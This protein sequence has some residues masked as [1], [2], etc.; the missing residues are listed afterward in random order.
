MLAFDLKTILP[1]LRLWT[2]QGTDHAGVILVDEKTFAQ[3]DTGG[4]SAGL[5][6]LWK[7]ESDAIWTNRVIYLRTTKP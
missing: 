4:L 7:A 1:L 6:A 2:E 5:C 3:N